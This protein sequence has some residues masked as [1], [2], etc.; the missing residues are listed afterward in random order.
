MIR[1]IIRQI[2]EESYQELLNEKVGDF[3]YNKT[4]DVPET[5]K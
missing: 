4:F 1:K 5:Y 3:N 2:I